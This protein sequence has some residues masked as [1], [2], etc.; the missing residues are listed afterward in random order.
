MIHSGHNN[1]ITDI[2]LA[3]ILK[4]YR[5]ADDVFREDFLSGVIFTGL[6]NGTCVDVSPAANQLLESLGNSWIETLDTNDIDKI[7]P[8]GPYVTAGQH[9][10]EIFRLYDDVQGAFMNGIIPQRHL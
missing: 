5:A 6:T 2:W 8:P 10:L 7:P 4:F 3:Q 1:C 9:L